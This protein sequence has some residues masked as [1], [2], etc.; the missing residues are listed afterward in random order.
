MSIP[1]SGQ[2]RIPAWLLPFA[3]VLFGSIYGALRPGHPFPAYCF[4]AGEFSSSGCIF[5]CFCDHERRNPYN[6]EEHRGSPTWEFWRVSFG[7][8]GEAASSGGSEG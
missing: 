4:V 3:L 2:Y 1:D 7:L 6:R 5:L 8:S